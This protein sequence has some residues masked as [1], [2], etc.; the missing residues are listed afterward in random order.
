MPVIVVCP[1][2]EGSWPQGLDTVESKLVSVGGYSQV[3]NVQ[4]LVALRAG[5][6]A[7]VLLDDDEVVERE[8]LMAGLEA[9]LSDGHR[10]IAG[11]YVNRDGSYLLP[12]SDEP[13][14]LAW[15]KREAM[16]Q[17]L[18]DLIAGTSDVRA[19]MIAFGGAMALHRDVMREV[20]FDP[21]LS[22]GEDIDYVFN[23]ELMG[24]TFVFDKRFFVKHLPPPNPWPTWR[25][26]EQ[27]LLRFSYLQAK[28]AQSPVSAD[29]LGTYPG[30]YVGP[31]L[32]TRARAAITALR[33]KYRQANDSAGL[34][35]CD[36]MLQEFGER[37]FVDPLGRYMVLRK[38]WQS[39][40]MRF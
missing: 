21:A 33:E 39:L 2:D 35:A 26:L 16:N 20:C 11:Y 7:A 38:K 10:A 37:R 8:D 31:E 18:D 19:T 24:Q 27:D 30:I 28:V 36:R 32:Q 9:D 12:P 6:D 29:K 5:A 17:A 15:G 14:E 34:T 4:L 25:G 23:A 13:W 22:R 1:D 3:R 40:T